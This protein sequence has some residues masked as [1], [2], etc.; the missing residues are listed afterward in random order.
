VK[1]VIPA[2]FKLP[3]LLM[4]F[5]RPENSA[6]PFT[7]PGRR[8]TLNCYYAP[9]TSTVA[10]PFSFVVPPNS[11]RTTAISGRYKQA[12]TFLLS[13][14]IPFEKNLKKAHRTKKKYDFQ[15]TDKTLCLSLFQ[16]NFALF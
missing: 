1:D 4:A 8:P 14:T 15:C 7:I 5:Q 16:Y 11:G 12:A 6:K 10:C 3:V 2:F 13:L 9:F